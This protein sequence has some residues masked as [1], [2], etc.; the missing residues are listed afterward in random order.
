M[1]K[2]KYFVLGMILVGLAA[3]IVLADVELKNN[4]SILGAWLLESVAP[5]LEKTRIPENRTW[6]FKNDGTIVMSGYN[7]HFQ[8]EDSVTIAYRVENGE[9]VSEQPGRPGK[10][11]VYSVYALDDAHMI[12][13][14]G[15]EGFY[16]FVRK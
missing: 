8:R 1:K 16:F 3:K 9:I 13:K 2:L 7:R 14:G 6:E 4:S 12:L 10:P 5:S 15:I 11:I